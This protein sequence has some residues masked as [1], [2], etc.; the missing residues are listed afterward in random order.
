[1][2]VV[3]KSIVFQCTFL[4][5]GIVGIINIIFGYSIIFGLMFI[6]VN[7]ELSNFVGYFFG[8]MLSFLLNRSF[9]FQSKN[10]PLTEMPKFY[11]VTGIAYTVNLTILTFCYRLVLINPYLS[12]IIAGSFYVAIGYFLSKIWVFNCRNQ[13]VVGRATP[14]RN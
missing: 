1:M 9:T 11:L 13:P 5:Y 4:K 7:P 2:K 12:Q 14:L 6:K 8:I 3:I 10:S